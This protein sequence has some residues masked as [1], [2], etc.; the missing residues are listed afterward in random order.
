MYLAMN[1]KICCKCKE[2]DHVR[3][4]WRDRESKDGLNHLCTPCARI[5]NTKYYRKEDWVTRIARSYQLSREQ[6]DALLI[7]QSG[8]CAICGVAFMGTH[9]HRPQI[10]HN[11][12]TGKNRGLLCLECNLLVG[13]LERRADKIPMAYAYLQEYA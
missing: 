7:Q 13:F 8:R 9:K 2:Y 11:H 3:S 10:D 6:F 4:Y 12:D 5:K 1:T